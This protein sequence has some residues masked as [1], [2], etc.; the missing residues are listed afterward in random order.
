MDY[1]KRKLEKQE[2]IEET[3]KNE[4]I[5]LEVLEEDSIQIT[6]TCF[7]PSLMSKLENKTKFEYK[8]IVPM[9][10]SFGVQSFEKEEE[11]KDADAFR[12]K[13]QSFPKTNVFPQSAFGIVI[14]N[15]SEDDT[16][17]WGTGVLIGPDI[18]LTAAY[19]VYDDE[20]PVRKRFPYIKFAPGATGDEAPFGE[21]EVEE[22]IATES[23]VK[24]TE[25][26]ER[27]GLNVYALLILRNSI[28]RETGY[29]GLH[30]VAAEHTYL[31][32]EREIFVMG[33]N[34]DNKEGQESDACF[35]Q[36]R[37]KGRTSELS[38]EEKQLIQYTCCGPTDNGILCIREKDTF[39][40][41]G[42]HLA[43]IENSNIACLIT[44]EDFQS[45]YQ[46]VKNTKWTR[47]NDIIQ[48]KED[49]TGILKALSL[50]SR[51]LRQWGL[52]ALLEFK[53]DHL[54]AVNLDE[55][56][57]EDK[58]IEELCNR[59][60]WKEL[61]R[62]DLSRNKFG[63]N[64]CL[65]LSSNTT[66]KNLKSLI[67]QENKIS[68]KGLIK[69][70]ENQDWNNLEEIDFFGNE[71]EDQGAIVIAN[72][73]LWIKLRKLCLAN[74]SIGPE[75][76]AAIGEN[77]FW[78]DLEEL[79]LSNNKIGDKGAICISSNTSWERLRKLDISS[80]NIGDEGGAAIGN[81]E[82]WRNLEELSI[83][84]NP[85][86]VKSMVCIGSNTSW[87]NL[88]KL[89]MRLNNL[90]EEALEAFGKNITWK[91]LEELHIA[92]SEMKTKGATCI[93]SNSIWRNLRKIDFSGN[94]F[95]EEGAVA[96]G[97]NTSWRNLE[98]LMLLNNNIKNEG[99]ICIG[100]NTSWS[101]LRIL[102]L[103]KN[104]I[105]D[106]GAEAIGKN[107]TWKN[108][109]FLG[110]QINEIGDQGAIHIGRNTSWKNLKSLYLNMNKI[111]DLG[112]VELG[113]NAAWKKLQALWLDFNQIGWKTAIEIG[114]NSTC[115]K[116][117]QRISLIKNT[118]FSRERLNA[119]K[120]FLK[121]GERST[122]FKGLDSGE[123]LEI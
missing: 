101:S 48:S 52:D 20:E 103:P 120:A 45:L 106:E 3:I 5:G 113:K 86:G 41:I 108:L 47:V 50:K 44:K 91:N 112:G 61:Q 39:S 18:V 31:H 79:D 83:S 23:Y 69:M 62:L 89:K 73:T 95:F 93:S 60:E 119:L 76:G 17:K 21:I 46:L 27:S 56:F 28:G 9:Q 25:E 4:L 32:E 65:T 29:L 115:W 92:T 104:K 122:L 13:R 36:W 7:R 94:K 55:N 99:A 70:I 109:E 26:T 34:V 74:N 114:R 78:K 12:D 10:D 98:V 15:K 8:K 72:N 53:L 63:G 75:G 84:R 57:I 123:V 111:G 117:I 14:V 107:T 77:T 51:Y 42:V 67:L 40:V 88:K 19:N 81:N 90:S 110:L 33:Y 54:E 59:S 38:G 37:E 97:K 96:I 116:S 35:E 121:T 58:N 105:G 80:N 30:V 102:V 22:V 16:A 82:S 100:S 11:K 66:W 2:T 24:K 85:L 49:K 68:S 6:T 64:G 1:L 87:T 43:R 71:I 118:K